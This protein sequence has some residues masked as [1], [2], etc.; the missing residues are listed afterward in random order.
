MPSHVRMGQVVAKFLSFI[1]NFTIKISSYGKM[2]YCC[3]D[4]IYR[5]IYKGKGKVLH[6][7]FKKIL[8]YFSSLRVRLQF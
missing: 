4:Y 6:Y 3:Y 5:K 2:H 8:M 1:N 7:M